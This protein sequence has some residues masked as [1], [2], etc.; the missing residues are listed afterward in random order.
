MADKDIK[1][2]KFASSY[3][4]IS[5]PQCVNCQWRSQINLAVCVA[6]PTGIP[7]EILSGGA[8]HDKPYKGDHGIQFKAK[9]KEAK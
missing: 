8:K 7:D 3:I 4:E 1:K 9:A 6:F 5:K 2:D